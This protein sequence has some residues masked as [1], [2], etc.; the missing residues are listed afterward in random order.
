MFAVDWFAGRQKVAELA[1][2]AGI[3]DISGWMRPSDMVAGLEGA[4]NWVSKAGGLPKFITRIKKH[5]EKKGMTESHAIATAV[6][7]VKK[8]CSSGDTNFPGKQNVSAGSRAEACA[9]AA[10]WKRKKAKAGK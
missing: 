7:V 6:N 4:F 10:D 5:L 3:A 2:E 1:E 9:A 8:M